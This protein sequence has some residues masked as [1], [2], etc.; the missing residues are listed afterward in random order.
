[1]QYYSQRNT[2][3]AKKPNVPNTLDVKF[4]YIYTDYLG[5][6]MDEPATALRNLLSEAGKQIRK[7]FFI[8]RLKNVTHLT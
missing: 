8:Q 4:L 1:M 5:S 3:Y 6:Q 2:R 7:A